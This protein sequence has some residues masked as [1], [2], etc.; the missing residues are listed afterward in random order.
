MKIKESTIE[1]PIATLNIQT[2][3]ANNAA[4]TG[5]FFVEPQAERKIRRGA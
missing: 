2:S 5:V 3:M 4:N 1:N